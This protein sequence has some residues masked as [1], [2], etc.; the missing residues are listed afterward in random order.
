MLKCMQMRSNNHFVLGTRGSKLALV[1]TQL[2]ATALRQAHSDL[3]IDIEI[4][5][6]KG[7]RLLDV[8]LSKVGD[9]GLFVKDIEQALSDG[10]IDLAVH[11]AKD[12]PS[13]L[14]D[15]L[16][17]GAIPARAD[18]RDVLVS[19]E[20]SRH[21]LTLEALP[22]QGLPLPHI[23]QGAH[24]GS[25]SLRRAS[26][27]LALRPDVH[28]SDVRGN[29]DTR[30]R[31]LAAGEYDAIILA[32][33]GLDRLGLRGAQIQS[34]GAAF[35]VQPFELD[36]MLPAVAQGALAIE[37]R[38]G[39]MRTLEVLRA[40]NDADTHACVTAERAFLRRL[41]GGCQVPVAAYAQI[42]HGVLQLR[43]L[44]AALDGTVMVRGTQ[45]GVVNEAERLGQLLAERLLA[46]GGGT[47]LL[48][49]RTDQRLAQVQTLQPFHG[50]RIVVTRPEAHANSLN[51]KLQALGA[52]VIRYPVIAYAPPEDD[53]PVDVAIQRLI[54]GEFDW[55]TLTSVQTVRVIAAWLHAAD[56]TLPALKIA[57]VGEVTAA[58][59]KEAL[60]ITPMEV[61]EQFDADHLVQ[62]MGNVRG[63]R[64][65]LLNADIARPTVQQMLQ[66]AGAQVH[67]V[68][69]YHTVAA[70]PAPDEADLQAM[71][72]HGEIDA[73]TLTSASTVRHL[74]ERV[75]PAALR[76][77]CAVLVCI[78]PMTA[79]AL[80]EH[81]LPNPIVATQ[82]THEGLIAALLDTLKTNTK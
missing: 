27:L 42:D 54:D 20:E 74:I 81:G 33:A 8:A 22:L 71:L 31:K 75:G 76:D 68:V 61:P 34:E 78:G 53:R 56:K 5:S 38:S 25:S 49:L 10:R 65:L 7:D 23:P 55:L 11:S 1:Q 15:I 37:C 82:A 14:P 26:Q 58:V 24:I 39:D 21:S 47:I 40:L 43:G 44:I 4:I 2:V 57:A 48:K 67:R 70:K 69:A 35:A 9:Q 12:L 80:I 17:L 18:V 19:Q 79:Q 41:E 60:G 64:V 3:Q 28:I 63:Q 13:Q 72:R 51:E 66:N 50:K 29:V 45:A 59:C 16:T 30:L 32:A 73:I 36:Q 52:I 62:A 6:T 46:E 77:S